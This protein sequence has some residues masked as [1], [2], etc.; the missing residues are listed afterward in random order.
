[1]LK[2]IM[3]MAGEGSRFTEAGYTTKKP[4]IDVNGVPMFVHAERCIGLD[5]DERIFIVRKEHN[6]REDVLAWYPDAIVI[7]LDR[8]TNGTACSILTARLHLEEGCSMFVSNCDQHTLWDTELVNNAINDDSIDGIISVFSCPERNPKWSYA[9]V[10]QQR[11]VRVAEK[12]PISDWATT[13]WY[14]WRDSKD[15]I[16]SAEHMINAED[17]VNNEYYTCPTYNHML[18]LNPNANILP[19]EVST[20]IGIGTP[21]D[22]D[23]F[24]KEVINE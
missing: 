2:L 19:V 5:F 18:E 24:L 9:L 1:M 7:E 3:P 21:D 8:L 15:F 10:E 11:I 22:L 23:S 12:D 20:M 14:Y 16:N 17:K 4:M 13:G 6:I